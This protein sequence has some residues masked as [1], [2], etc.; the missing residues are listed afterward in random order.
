MPLVIECL[1]SPFS[2]GPDKQ[3]RPRIVFNVAIQRETP[4]GSFDSDELLEQIK[5]LITSATEPNSWREAD[6]E[7]NIYLGVL[8]DDSSSSH[9][10]GGNSPRGIEVALFEYI[11]PAN[12]Q[13]IGSG[14]PIIENHRVQVLCRAGN[15]SQYRIA[16]RQAERIYRILDYA[17]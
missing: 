6:T 14:R 16:R 5:D 9:Q 15:R 13:V 12:E 7:D 11:S 1:Q 4:T 10:T 8:P 3:G 2:T 17:G